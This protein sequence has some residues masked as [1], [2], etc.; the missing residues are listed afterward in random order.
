MDL[1]SPLTY[2]TTTTKPG[3]ASSPRTDHKSLRTKLDN[4]QNLE[5]VR[6]SYLLRA[7]NGV[8]VFANPSSV[9]QALHTSTQ[10]LL[11][12]GTR[13]LGNGLAHVVT[14]WEHISKVLLFLQTHFRF[15]D[16]EEICRGAEMDVDTFNYDKVGPLDSDTDLQEV[17]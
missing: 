14:V 11:E 10:Y 16:W 9:T 4:H 17:L 15:G 3:L 2:P 8:R 6:A 5:E 12:G 13:S 7:V 1:A